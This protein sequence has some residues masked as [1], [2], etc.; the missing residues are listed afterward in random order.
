LSA[1]RGRWRPSGSGDNPAD[2]QSQIQ[3]SENLTID[4]NFLEDSP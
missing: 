4:V 1:I 2:K 3:T